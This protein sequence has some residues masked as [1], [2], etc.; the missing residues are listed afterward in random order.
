MKHSDKIIKRIL[1]PE[2]LLWFYPLLLIIP[3]VILDITEFS[4]P[5]TKVTNVLLPFG[6][7]ML[8]LC[9]WRNVGRTALFLFPVLFYGAFQIVLLYLYGE[10]VI[11]VDMIINLVTTNVSEAV[12]LLGNLAIAVITV[13]IVYV[14][15]LVWCIISA[16]KRRTACP[17]A[18]IRARQ[19]GIVCTIVGIACM[20][21]AF[22]SDTEFSI[23]RDI[24]PVNV[25]DNTIIAVK[26]TQATRNYFTTS[27]DFSYNARSTRSDDQKEVFV[28]V[29]GETSRAD[30]WQ[31]FGYNRPT[32]PRLSKRPDLL[33]FPK[34]LS[35]NNT[36]HKSVP[37]MLSWV[38]SDNFGDS[39]YTS[40]SLI[41]AFNEAG[42][43]TAFFSNQGRNRS[44]IEFFAHEAQETI[45][46]TDS[47]SHRDDELLPLMRRCLEQSSSNKI[48]VILHTYGSHF[49]YKE[50]YTP[51][52]RRFIPDSNTDADAFNR[53]KLVN[54]YDNT[55]VYTD[56]ILDEIIK[57]LEAQNCVT[58]MMYVSDHGEDIF[59]DSRNRFLHA[60]PVPT[61]WQI[62]VPLLIWMS[63]HM[64]QEYP[65]LYINA[66][67]HTANNVSSSRSVFDTMLEL[68]GI[69][70]PYCDPSKSLLDAAYKETPRQYLNDHNEVVG[71]EK[72]G[73][74]KY[75]F[76][77]LKS[78]NISI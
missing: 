63:H 37:L 55:I 53:I 4:S 12:E 62:H 43:H 23:R 59:D 31:I 1:S 69:S 6:I 44:F 8:V 10:S 61:Y 77:M 49:N 64:I 18:L 11:A 17:A 20:A 74:R 7:Y 68:S 41:S 36:T 9:I 52:Q 13:I 67:R 38:S 26:R 32:N 2:V 47:G 66:R 75:D 45:F 24:F 65:D 72:S 76:D 22:T 25:I 30:N 58:G 19:I 40:K 56:Y 21:I 33:L 16:V 48:L 39:I 3:N 27:S 51:A 54:A 14:P 50:R 29:I 28:L 15:T 35:E 73:L 60:S 34:T 57:T 46:L 42:F 5:L 78:K 71:F 70:S